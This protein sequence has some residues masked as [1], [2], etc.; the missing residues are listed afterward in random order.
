MQS[1]LEKVKKTYGETV[2]EIVAYREY[3]P[4]G[5]DILTKV[6]YTDSEQ[7]KVWAG[8]TVDEFISE[9]ESERYEQNWEFFQDGLT[10]NNLGG[11]YS[12]CQNGL[13]KLGSEG[14]RKCLRI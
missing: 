4:L 11:V 5:D 3:S 14:R 7:M 10:T 1:V 12:K 2:S 6:E 8:R 9:S 13:C